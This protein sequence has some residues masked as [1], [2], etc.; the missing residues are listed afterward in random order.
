M[1]VYARK[2]SKEVCL[3]V[4]RLNI[5]NSA[6]SCF[7]HLDPIAKKINI[8]FDTDNPRLTAKE[9]AD[10]TAACDAII[11]TV[12]EFKAVIEGDGDCWFL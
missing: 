6:F 4:H 2:N 12:S 7:P 3:N 11:K 10:L 9:C 1:P 5:L 8:C